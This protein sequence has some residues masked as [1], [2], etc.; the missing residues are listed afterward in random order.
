MENIQDSSELN[1]AEAKNEHRSTINRTAPEVRSFPVKTIYEIPS[2][3]PEPDWIIKGILPKYGCGILGGKP[4]VRKTWAVLDL[5]VSVVTRSKF[6]GK[7]EVH[8]SGEILVFCAEDSESSLKRRVL[9]IAKHRGIREDELLKFKFISAA[10]IDLSDPDDFERLRLTIDEHKPLIVAMD[11]L[12]RVVSVDENSSKAIGETLSQIRM[13]QR[14]KNVGFIFTHHMGKRGAK[15]GHMGDLFRGS[16]DFHSFG[17][18]NIYISPVKDD[19]DTV[20]MNFELR[21][22]A[23]QEPAYFTLETANDGTALAETAPPNPEATKKRDI[24]DA[25]LAELANA[26]RSGNELNDILGGNRGANNEMF[27]QMAEA[28][29]IVRMGR[30]YC[31]SNGTGSKANGAAGTGTSSQGTQ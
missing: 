14:E 18:F 7:Y 26:S 12:R 9:S 17:D 24:R 2:V 30:K 3:A 16:S 8:E 20:K 23:P 11:P 28:G 27:K 29:L 4:K 21:D 13:L 25:V 6:L 15:D 5:L 31:L 10:R 19:Q 22:A 1:S